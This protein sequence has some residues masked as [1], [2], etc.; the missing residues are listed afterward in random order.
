MGIVVSSHVAYD[1]VKLGI[2]TTVTTPNGVTTITHGNPQLACV[3]VASV[4]VM[5]GIYCYYTEGIEI[6]RNTDNNP[7]VQ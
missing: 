4:C 2:D 1:C 7:T 6:T 3:G 5:Y